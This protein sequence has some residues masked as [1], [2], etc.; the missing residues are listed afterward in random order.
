MYIVRVKKG[1]E[2][3]A[4]SRPCRECW[5]VMDTL[6][7]RK[8]YYTTGEGTWTCERVASMEITHRSSGVLALQAYREQERDEKKRRKS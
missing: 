3:W 6:G 1:T 2:D 8:V 7:I 4:M 5:E